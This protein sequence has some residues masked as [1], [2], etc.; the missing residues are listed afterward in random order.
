MPESSRSVGHTDLVQD[1]VARVGV[2]DRLVSV[3]GISVT[4]ELRGP[5]RVLSC[6]GGQPTNEGSD[7]ARRVTNS[8]GHGIEEARDGFLSDVIGV[9]TT[10]EAGRGLARDPHE[11]TCLTV[12]HEDRSCGDRPCLS[13][14]V[15]WPPTSVGGLSKPVGRLDDFRF[16]KCLTIVR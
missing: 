14:G 15:V 6:L 2:F 11:L 10:Q 8:P 9:V 13:M 4:E 7:V 3:G 16:Q 12:F 1:Q 5:L